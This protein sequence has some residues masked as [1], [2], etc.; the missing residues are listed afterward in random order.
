MCS[1][2]SVQLSTGT[3]IVQ[4]GDSI[5]YRLAG[6]DEVLEGTWGYPMM[7]G[8]YPSGYFQGF[9]R[10]E[11]WRG[12][13]RSIG[14]RTGTVPAGDFAEGHG[15]SVAWA[16]RSA[17]I[18]CLHK[19]GMVLILTRSAS[20]AERARLRHYRVPVQVVGAKL[21]LPSEGGADWFGNQ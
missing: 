15:E 13:W 9:A 4:P 21:V 19:G 1:K 2:L 12:T 5:P 20:E 17:N 11:T 3:Q 10:V 6:S 14:W 16:S 8:P 18:A 7:W